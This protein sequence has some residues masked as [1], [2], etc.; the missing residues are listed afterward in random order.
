[1]PDLSLGNGFALCEGGECM[2][3]L[4][5]NYVYCRNGRNHNKYLAFHSVR[6]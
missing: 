2:L 6:K 5:I 4:H 3:E 1:M